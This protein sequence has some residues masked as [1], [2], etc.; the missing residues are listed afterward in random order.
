MARN[1]SRHLKPVGSR[2]KTDNVLGYSHASPTHNKRAEER[3]E[4]NTTERGDVR[5][6]TETLRNTKTPRRPFQRGI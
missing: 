4:T 2:R 3:R 6:Q 5:Q 1:D